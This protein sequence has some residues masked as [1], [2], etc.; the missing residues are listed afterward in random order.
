MKFLLNLHTGLY[1][2]GWVHILTYFL[3]KLYFSQYGKED[4]NRI[5]QKISLF[6]MKN[7]YFYGRAKENPYF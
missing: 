2:H 3:I 7:Y 4:G 6:P 1:R 5:Y